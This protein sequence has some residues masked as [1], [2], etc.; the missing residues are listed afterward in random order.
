MSW[1]G[2]WRGFIARWCSAFQRWVRSPQQIHGAAPPGLPT[3]HG[4]RLGDPITRKPCQGLSQR[5]HRA[6]A[7]WAPLTF[8]KMSLPWGRLRGPPGPQKWALVSQSCRRPPPALPLG[9]RVHGPLLAGRSRKSCHVVLKGQRAKD[10]SR[11]PVRAAGQ[12][13]GRG[14]G[15]ASASQESLILLQALVRELVFF[16]PWSPKGGHPTWLHARRFTQVT[17]LSLMSA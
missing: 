7:A 3:S 1:T 6:P 11:G 16:V 15:Q 9:Q 5:P 13:A 2:R 12:G 17:S 4:M 14:Q 8:K 10:C